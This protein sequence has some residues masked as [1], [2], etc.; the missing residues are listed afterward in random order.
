MVTA[1]VSILSG[2][3][4]NREV[5]MTGEITLRGQVLAIG[6]VKEKLLAA[7]RAGMQTVVLPRRN[8]KDLVDVPPALRRKLQLVFAD[9]VEDVLAAALQEGA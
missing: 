1:L 9:R 2:R 5:A 3:P 8:E 6:G 4:V 7:V